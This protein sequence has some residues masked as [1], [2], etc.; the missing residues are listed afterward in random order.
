MKTT[1]L[2]EVMTEA[3]EIEARGDGMIAHIATLNERAKTAWSGG[4]EERRGALLSAA[5][6]AILALHAHDAEAAKEGAG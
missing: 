2:L 1:T 3:R 4:A 6:R 5:A